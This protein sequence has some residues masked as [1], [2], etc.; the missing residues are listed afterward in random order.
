M[1][2]ELQ[3]AKAE[4]QTLRETVS[5]LQTRVDQG[6]DRIKQMWRENCRYVAEVDDEL[7]R[8][9]VEIQQLQEMIQELQTAATSGGGGMPH[10]AS[11]PVIPSETRPVGTTGTR[12]ARRGKAPPVDPSTGEDAETTLDDWLPSLQRAAEWNGWGE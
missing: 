7:S 5:S 6:K 10:A 1:Q 9:D 12:G 11:I 4:I 2:A 8:K 3:E